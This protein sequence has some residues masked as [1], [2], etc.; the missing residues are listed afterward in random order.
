MKYFVQSGW[1]TMSN[2]SSDASETGSIFASG[3]VAEQWRRGAAQRD[4]VTGPASEMMLDLGKLGSGSR[5]LDVAAGTGDQTL[6][7][8]RRVG[9]T[10]YVLATDNSTSMLN[11]AAEATRMLVSPT[12]TLGSWTPRTSISTR[13]RSTRSYAGWVS[14]CFPIQS[15]RL[16]GCTAL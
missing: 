3:E 15:K 14:C 7:A 13:T 9:P 6:M 4:E 16:S 5:V 8:A 1:E 11:V 12:L 2:K 10:G